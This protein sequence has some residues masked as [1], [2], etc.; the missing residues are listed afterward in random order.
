MS[1]W[2]TLGKMNRELNDH[3]NDMFIKRYVND[4]RRGSATINNNNS[5][6]SNILSDMYFSFDDVKGS[7]SRAKNNKAPGLD[8]ITNELLKNGGD[9]LV[10]CLTDLFNRFLYIEKTPN[11]WNKGIIIPIYKKGNKNDLDNYRGITL[12][13]C[14]SKIFNRLVCN[15]ITNFLENNNVLTEVQGGFRKDHRC[16][17][18]IFNLKSIIA[19]RSAE[20]KSTYLAFL[21][22]RKAFDTVWR[23]GLLSVAWNIGIRGKVWNVLDEL[24]KNVEC[25]VKF[26]DVVTDFF[27]IDE[28]LKQGCVL[29]PILFCMYINELT[30]MFRDN[31]VGSC[32]FDVRISCLFWADDVVL[33]ADNENDLQNMLNIASDFSRKW[34]LDFNYNKSNVVII[35]KRK[36]ENK[37]WSLGNRHIK[38]ADSYKY[39]GFNISRNFSDHVH[40]KELIQKGNRLIGYIKSIINSQDDFNRVYYGNILWKSL[41]LPSIN[42]ACAISTYSTSDYKKLESLQLQMARSI[43]KAPR[44]TPS[45]ALLGDLGWDCIES[46][47]NQNKIKYFNRVINMDSHRWPKLL[48]N[49]IFTVFNNDMHLKWTWLDSVNN[50]LKNCGFDHVLTSVN[51]ANI[52]WFN[53][54]VNINRQQCHINWYNN[55]CS[56]TSLH[57]YICLKNQPNLESYLIDKLDFIGSSLKFKARSNTLPLNGRTSSWNKQKSGSC[58]LCNDDLEDIRHF[59]F[60]CP[61]TNNIR[62]DEFYKLEQKLQEG[63]LF[64]AWLLFISSNI[65]IKLYMLLGGDCAQLLPALSSCSVDIVHVLL[66]AACK[67]LLKRTWKARNSLMV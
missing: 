59:I 41:A 1:Y 16:D 39:L 40:V 66:D 10:K 56:K 8:S 55:A 22:F 42:Y 57:D 48:F 23:E 44:N 54:F 3:Q 31:N 67:S 24:Y 4:I 51:E 36:N 47:H 30:K 29:S 64:S 18:H 53:S 63:G 19:T 34:K 60:S 28:G 38:E 14:V 21:D 43:L 37:V 17:D 6:P 26:G 12:T 32:I 61:A 49:A 7:I 58:D 27:S 9:S 25:N 5:V 62:I 2:N 11:E 50:I 46:I 52:P 33:I 35:G 13:S 15:Q 20:N 65:D 45:A